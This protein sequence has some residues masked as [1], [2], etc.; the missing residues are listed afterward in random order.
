MSDQQ[1]P[2]K[3]AI[4]TDTGCLL[5]RQAVDAVRANDGE[6]LRS[7]LRDLC[8][9]TRGLREI[10]RESQTRRSRSQTVPGERC[11]MD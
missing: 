3:L 9:V 1:R 4:W 10:Y 5:I 7:A 6:K 11:E 2:D 8:L